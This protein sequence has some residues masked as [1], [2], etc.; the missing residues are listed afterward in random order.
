MLK[1]KCQSFGHLIRRADS[2]EKTLMLGKIEGRRRRGRQRMRW[3]DGTIDS[4]DMS[5]SKLQEV[6][7]REGGQGILACCSLWGHKEAG[8]TE[9][10]NSNQ[11][12]TLAL[13]FV[14]VILSS[15]KF[16]STLPSASSFCLKSFF[17]GHL[18]S[19]AAAPPTPFI[20]PHACSFFLHF[21]PWHV[22]SSNIV[23]NQSFIL[24]SL[25]FSWNMHSAR[26][27]IFFSF[28]HE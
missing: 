20:L 26:A 17:T 21:L 5:L 23:Y 9:R 25:F 4:V 22:S 7:G 12:S 27:E 18:L 2:L 13:A 16:F 10:L 24:Y 11:Q 28:A 3:L 6:V 14:L 19:Q 1:L 15:C 8:T